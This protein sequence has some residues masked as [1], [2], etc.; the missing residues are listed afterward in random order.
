MVRG[1]R[2]IVAGRAGARTHPDAEVIQLNSI[3]RLTAHGKAGVFVLRCA[4]IIDNFRK[5]HRGSE[6]DNVE[7][8]TL[9]AKWLSA[10]WHSPP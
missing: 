9:E 7:I 5:Q 6:A 10:L 4:S 2:W 1:R 8:R 3:F